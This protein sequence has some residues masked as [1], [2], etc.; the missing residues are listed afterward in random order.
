M[1]EKEFAETNTKALKDL[2]E[3]SFSD[4]RL[5]FPNWAAIEKLAAELPDDDYRCNLTGYAQHGQEEW[6]KSIV[7]AKGMLAARDGLLKIASLCHTVKEEG[8]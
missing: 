3:P 4:L 2:A 1:N 7:R 6:I 8:T 5:S